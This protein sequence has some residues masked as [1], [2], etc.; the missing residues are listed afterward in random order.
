MHVGGHFLENLSIYLSKTQLRTKSNQTL[1]NNGEASIK[2]RSCISTII[3]GFHSRLVLTPMSEYTPQDQRF[4]ENKSNGWKVLPSQ[5][6][7]TTGGSWLVKPFVDKTL[8]IKCQ[9][10]KPD[11]KR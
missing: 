9:K 4:G 6:V 10:Q 3:V 1:R 11:N 8:E 7:P 5:S 2:V